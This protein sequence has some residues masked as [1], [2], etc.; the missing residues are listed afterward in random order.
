M[1]AFGLLSSSS[2][3][4]PIAESESGSSSETPDA[5]QESQSF[6][7]I[8]NNVCDTESEDEGKAVVPLQSQDV[9]FTEYMDESLGKHVRLFQDG[10]IVQSLKMVPGSDGFMVAEWHDGSTSKTEIPVLL[11]QTEVVRK[12]VVRKRPS[13]KAKAI[14][15]RP[16]SANVVNGASDE[17]MESDKDEE[18]RAHV[19]KRPATANVDGD[20]CLGD[21]EKEKLKEHEAPAVKTKVLKK[22][23]D[24]VFEF[25]ENRFELFPKGCP[26]C[27]G[28]KGCTKSCWVY[29][30]KLNK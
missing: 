25:P 2:K 29:R 21:T 12:E 22:V 28:V 23:S 26:K 15:K 8:M 16:A 30:L 1:R 6:D 13:S 20:E 3:D 5:T 19:A 18:L 4:L 27:R 24:I 14:L 10:A 11:Y 9:N 17:S 7:W